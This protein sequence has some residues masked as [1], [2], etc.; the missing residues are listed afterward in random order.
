MGYERR[1]L[2]KHLFRAAS[3][4]RADGLSKSRG[5]EHGVSKS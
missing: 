3:G 2:K 5:R 4:Y 1:E